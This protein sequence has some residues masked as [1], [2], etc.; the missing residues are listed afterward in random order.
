M[1]VRLRW[2]CVLVIISYFGSSYMHMTSLWHSRAARHALRWRMI[3]PYK[4]KATHGVRGT[5][6]LTPC[7]RGAL[8]RRQAHVWQLLARLARDAPP[9]SLR[10]AHDTT[11]AMLVR[12]VPYTMSMGSD[13]LFS[14]CF[15]LSWYFFRILKELVD[16]FMFKDI[17]DKIWIFRENND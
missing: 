10:L 7:I 6:T 8:G 15:G 5:P 1:N 3:L 4:V 17:K 13:G 14:S 11:Q 2:A 9:T 16:I 12:L